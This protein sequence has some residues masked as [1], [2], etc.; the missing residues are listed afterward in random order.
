[1]ISSSTDCDEWR[2]PPKAEFAVIGDP[3]EHSLSPRMHAAAFRALGLP[4]RFVSLRVPAGRVGECLESL[5]SAGY[6]GVNVT[7]PHKEEALVWAERTD[8]FSRRIRAANTVSLGERSAANTD[9]DGFLD[10]LAV[11]EVHPGSSALVLGAGG[12]A[13][14]VSAALSDAGYGLRLWNRTPERASALAESLGLPAA[15]LDVP[16]PEGV[17]LIV[18]ATSAGFAGAA[19]PVLWERAPDSALAYDLSYGPAP[20]PFLAEAACRGLRRTDGVPLLVAQ[21]A[22]SLEL[23]LGVSAPRDVML[24]AIR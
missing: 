8:K 16:D 12:A 7:V 14:A 23:W 2:S 4:Y 1:M 18:N 10:T 6:I 24:K 3:V 22:R 13:R 19:P 11:L 9:G 21:G 17:A 5:R 15:I 20:G